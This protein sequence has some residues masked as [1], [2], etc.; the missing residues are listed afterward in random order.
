MAAQLL[1]PLRI[2]CACPICNGNYETVLVDGTKLGTDKKHTTGTFVSPTVVIP[3]RS[4]ERLDVLRIKTK[5]VWIFF[6]NLG[7]I[8]SGGLLPVLLK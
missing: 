5:Q 3:D 6:C 1:C 4:E 7:N 8:I 2:G